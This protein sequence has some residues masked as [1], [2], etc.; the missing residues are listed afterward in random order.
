MYGKDYVKLYQDDVDEIEIKNFFSPAEVKIKTFANFQELNYDSLKGRLLSS[1]YIPLEDS[2]LYNE[3]LQALEN[4]FEKK[5]VNGKVM[6]EYE[7][8]LYYGKLND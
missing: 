7:T 3:M 2:P 5:N 8:K 1:S 6:M 4:I